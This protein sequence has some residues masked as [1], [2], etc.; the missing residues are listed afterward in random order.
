M[1]SPTSQLLDGFL[2]QCQQRVNQSLHR[3]LEGDFAS[4][5]LRDAMAHACLDGGKRIR[6]V[7]VYGSVQAVG[8]DLDWADNAACAVELMHSY[9]LVHDDLPAMDDDDLRRGKP[10][11]HKAFDE[12]TAILAGDALQS[13]AFQLLAEPVAA[14]NSDTQLKMVQILAAG[15]GFAGMAGGQSLDCEASSQQLDLTSLE[16]LHRSKTGALIKAS[17]QLGALCCPQLQDTEMIA[18]QDYAEI[19]GLAF[20]VQDD[21]LDVTGDT[22]TLGKPQG[23]DKELDKATYVSLLGLEAA[24]SKAAELSDVALESLS[25]FPASA[26]PLRELA[27]YIVNRIN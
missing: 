2:V 25:S 3:Q 6:P 12:A 20:Q 10:S 13:L 23:S 17:V 1:N 15:A 8:G 24:R 11:L 18:L 26:D 27:A 5:I 7:L 14:I 16:T 22:E 19:I 21:I 4:V 9:S